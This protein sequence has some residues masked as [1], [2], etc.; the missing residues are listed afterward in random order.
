[1][2]QKKIQQLRKIVS[3]SIVATKIAQLFGTAENEIQNYLLKI[4]K[5]LDKK[6]PKIKKVKKLIKKAEK[7][8]RKNNSIK[9]KV[10]K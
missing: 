4:K 10:C 6:K 9:N 7:H 3:I 8:A 5:E 1:M 2:N